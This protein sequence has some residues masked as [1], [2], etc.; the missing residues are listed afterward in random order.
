MLASRFYRLLLACL[1]EGFS[2]WKEEPLTF[3]DSEPEPD[4]SVTR[5]AEQDYSKAHPTTAE[6]VI[7]I[8]VSSAAL[9]RANADLYA[10]A[11][12]NEYWIVLASEQRIEVYRR[13]TEGHYQERFLCA[14][15]DTLQCVSLPKI[16]LR[17]SEL[18]A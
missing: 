13:P 7:E 3:L 2:V 5:G 15:S 8:A 16:Q 9:D 11:G 17:V 10:E 12:I 4:I 14:P 18:F 6:L 1:P